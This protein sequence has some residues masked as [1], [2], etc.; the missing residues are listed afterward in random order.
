MLELNE[1]S[2]CFSEINRFCSFEN[3][4]KRISIVINSYHKKDNIIMITNQ[5]YSKNTYV[6]TR[7]IKILVCQTQNL[8]EK[9]K[10]KIERKKQM[11]LKRQQEPNEII[12]ELI[13]DLE[14]F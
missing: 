10:K 2:Y 8:I 9:I 13:Q 12:V 6:Q 3:Y 14:N 4:V 7:K 11:M 1:I 5:N